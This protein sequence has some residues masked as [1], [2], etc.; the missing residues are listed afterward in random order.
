MGKENK[1]SEEQFIRQTAWAARRDAE[2]A[3]LLFFSFALAQFVVFSG[4]GKAPCNAF[5]LFL[6]MISPGNEIFS[7][8]HQSVLAKGGEST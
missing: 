6:S 8:A 2:R 3:A 1:V 5:F 4:G 7:S